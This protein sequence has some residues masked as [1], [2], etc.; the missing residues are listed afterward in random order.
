MRCFRFDHIELKLLFVS[1]TLPEEEAY[2]MV[3]AQQL[4]MHQNF[5]FMH[6]I[7]PCHVTQLPLYT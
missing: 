6:D 5:V 2:P 3:Q 7:A 4:S 1:H